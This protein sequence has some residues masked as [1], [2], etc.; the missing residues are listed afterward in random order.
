MVLAQEWGVSA[1]TAEEFLGAD[2]SAPGVNPLES[3][4]ASTGTVRD[5]DGSA[6][7]PA[8]GN[9]ALALLSGLELREAGANAEALDFVL[10][11]LGKPL[12]LD[13]P[14]RS[15]PSEHRP[16]QYAASLFAIKMDTDAERQYLLRLAHGLGL[17]ASVVR[18]V[19][20]C[21]DVGHA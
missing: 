16:V 10:S 11:E 13:G 12:D 5:G 15:A 17:Q 6:M 2:C 19:H 4:G 14:I 18:R 7:P 9:D 20:Q 3:L 21:L 1:E 8:L